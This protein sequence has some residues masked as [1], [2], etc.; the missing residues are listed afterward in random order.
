MTDEPIKK[1]DLTDFMTE[2]E[3][4]I[5]KITS[6]NPTIETP[7]EGT[8]GTPPPAPDD[9]EVAKL[10]KE[11]AASRK[12]IS[13]GEKAQK[14]KI[15]DSFDKERQEKYKDASLEV[16]EAVS[17]EQSDSKTPFISEDSRSRGE[18]ASKKK[19]SYLDRM[20]QKINYS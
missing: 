6:A 18:T 15:L 12:Q 9:S 5:E 10:K 20:N 4:K 19:H 16:L 8:G 13:D 2:I 17:D 11:L 7:S 14:K 1:K 3:T